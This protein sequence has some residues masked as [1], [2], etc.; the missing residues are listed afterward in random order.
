MLIDGAY[1]ET[2]QDLPDSTSIGVAEVQGVPTLTVI[3]TNAGSIVK[4]TFLKDL[5]ST[6]AGKDAAKT[7][8]EILSKALMNE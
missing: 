8:I 2:P 6:S 1:F 5:T 7:L 3:H 4:Q